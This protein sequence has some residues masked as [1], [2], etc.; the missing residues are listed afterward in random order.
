MRISGAPRPR[1]RVAIQTTVMFRYCCS[2]LPGSVRGATRPA[3]MSSPALTQSTQNR[4]SSFGSL[5]HCRAFTANCHFAR[6]MVI[7]PCIRTSAPTR[8]PSGSTPNASAPT[9]P[10]VPPPPAVPVSS[11][12]IH[13]TH[14]TQPVPSSSVNTVLP[15]FWFNETT[16][17]NI[18]HRRTG[19]PR[20]RCTA[21][22]P[23]GAGTHTSSPPTSSRIA[24]LGCEKKRGSRPHWD[25]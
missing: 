17:P 7:L 14:S 21:P 23:S 12:P 5:Q 13:T 8:S 15:G 24:S 19:L 9:V 4:I 3:S 6:Y 1:R 10:S 18:S 25:T 22:F 20:Y 16:Q 2:F 11:M